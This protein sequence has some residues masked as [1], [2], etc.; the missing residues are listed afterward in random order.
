MCAN[1]VA[2]HLRSDDAVHAINGHAVTTF[3]VAGDGSCLYLILFPPCEV[4]GTV[5]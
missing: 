3:R 4:N 5:A 1:E 2:S